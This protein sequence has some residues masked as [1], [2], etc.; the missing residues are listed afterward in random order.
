[1]R[2]SS[3]FPFLPGVQR[4]SAL[5]RS[6]EFGRLLEIRNSFLHS[7]DLDPK[8]PINW[9][10]QS[11][12]CG[13]PGVMNDLGLHVAHVPLRLG[14]KPISLYAQLQKI[15]NERPDGRGG[16]AA[17]DTWDNAMVH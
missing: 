7:S 11:K 14:W 12:F 3:E 13:E 17:C 2:V 10:R 6:G 9:K 1:M 16:M 5:I 15:Y 4:S 8:K